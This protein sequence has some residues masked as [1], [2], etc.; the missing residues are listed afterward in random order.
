ME[1]AP[2]LSF[3]RRPAGDVL[4]I[5]VVGDLVLGPATSLMR[6][7][8][9]SVLLQGGYR[10]VL[11]NLA[12][13]RNTDTTTAGLLMSVK[14]SAL[15]RNVQFKVCCLPPVLEQLVRRLRITEI[16]DIYEQEPAALESFQ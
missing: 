14:T 3:A 5:E 10:K 16:L 13:V 7:E 11:L 1:D 6:E 15:H 2:N 12:Q 4:V 9:Y 8:M